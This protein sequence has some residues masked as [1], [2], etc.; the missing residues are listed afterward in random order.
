MG[1]AIIV[2]GPISVFIDADPLGTCQIRPRIL[3]RREFEPVL[4]DLGGKVP[5]DMQYMGQEAVIYLDLNR[6]DPDVIQS[7][8]TPPLSDTFGVEEFGSIGAVMAQDGHTFAL[9]LNM[10]YLQ[11]TLVF[12]SAIFLGPDTEEDGTRHQIQR[13]AFYAIRQYDPSTGKFKLCEYK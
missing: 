9:S 2:S 10:P 4:N 13:T 11:K 3:W 5:F 8:R 6:H 12:G 7:L 1:E